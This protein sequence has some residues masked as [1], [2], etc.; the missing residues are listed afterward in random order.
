MTKTKKT[1][2]GNKFPLHL[3]MMM[4]VVFFS[5]IASIFLVISL[6][7]RYKAVV[8]DPGAPDEV[9]VLDTVKGSMWRYQAAMDV[10]VITYL[11][12]FKAGKKVPDRIVIKQSE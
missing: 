10:T 2:K 1:K 11:G 7:G 3:L 9:L 5:L 6:I 4:L 12:K 8:V